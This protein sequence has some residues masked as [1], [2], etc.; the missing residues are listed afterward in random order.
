MP[1]TGQGTPRGRPCG[2]PTV[3][4]PRRPCSDRA[5]SRDSCT[6]CPA[7][8]TTVAT[9]RRLLAVA[10]LQRP[11]YTSSFIGETFPYPYYPPNVGS[12]SRI[13]KY[14][15]SII[16]SVVTQ[17][18]SLIKVYASLGKVSLSSSSAV[19]KVFNFSLV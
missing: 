10:H 18:L 13:R 7:T 12:T 4:R 11:C 14:I 15:V 17:N 6:N 16:L 19:Y 8:V 3:R 2:R 9:A 1:T 5:G